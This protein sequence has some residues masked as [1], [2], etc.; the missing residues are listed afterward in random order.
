[1]PK[2]ASTKAFAAALGDKVGGGDMAG[3]EDWLAGREPTELIFECM[4][5]LGPQMPDFMDAFDSD[6]DLLVVVH[7]DHPHLGDII[8]WVEGQEDVVLL[9]GPRGPKP[10]AVFCAERPAWGHGPPPS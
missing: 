10:P 3:I 8:E 5:D 1:M 4:K 9:A 2:I 7:C 6:W